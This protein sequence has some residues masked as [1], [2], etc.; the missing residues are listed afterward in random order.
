MSDKIRV[1][2][3]IFFANLLSS[4]STVLATEE[5]LSLLGYILLVISDNDLYLFNCF[6]V[7]SVTSFIWSSFLLKHGTS[8]Y[9]LR[10]YHLLFNSWGQFLSLC[11][12][13]FSCSIPWSVSMF[14]LFA[15]WDRFFG[16]YSIYLFS[17]R[18]FSML[19][20][21]SSIFQIS[22]HDY[23]KLVRH[24]SQLY[25]LGFYYYR[26]QYWVLHLLST[27]NLF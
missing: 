6:P 3:V 4:W 23:Q 22:I 12:F 27:L 25:I 11:M 5:F 19:L 10:K 21:P 16:T 26:Y 15:K 9:H 8:L 14:S 18:W 17:F 13:P 24:S 2:F 7:T 20:L 1:K